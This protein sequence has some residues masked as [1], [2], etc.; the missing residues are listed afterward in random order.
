MKVKQKKNESLTELARRISNLAKL[1]YRDSVLREVSAVQ[2]QLAEF[3]IDG[4]SNSF[5][6]EDVARANPTTLLERPCYQQGRVKG[7]MSNFEAVKK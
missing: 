5:I 1:A 3:F 4:V 6:K 7:S 2:V